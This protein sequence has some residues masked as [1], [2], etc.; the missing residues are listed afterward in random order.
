MGCGLYRLCLRSIAAKLTRYTSLRPFVRDV[1]TVFRNSLAFNEDVPDNFE[2]RAMA[3]LLL[4]IFNTQ[5]RIL[6]RTV[7]VLAEQLHGLVHM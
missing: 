7:Q 5:L 1:R 3:K 2:I 6:A 4:G